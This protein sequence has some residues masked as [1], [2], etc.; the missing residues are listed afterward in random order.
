MSPGNTSKER[1]ITKRRHPKGSPDNRRR[2]KGVPKL[3]MSRKEEKL[4]ADPNR[5]TAEL[6]QDAGPSTII[7]S[8][9]NQTEREYQQSLLA[10]RKIIEATERGDLI[11]VERWEAIKNV[12][13]RAHA[14]M[15]PV[16]VATEEKLFK[17]QRTRGELI[18]V[19]AGKAL[20]TQLISPLIIYIRKMPDLARS[21][22]E[23]TLLQ[24]IAHGELQL[25]TEL[26]QSIAEEE[27]AE[28]QKRLKL[29]E[30]GD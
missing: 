28:L 24:T 15:T 22:S 14:K 2:I 26:A 19:D 25:I 29:R 23:K 8:L 1:V 7:Q 11:E 21:E 6:E 30:K 27:E 16:L 20:M 5:E 12:S 3:R 4:A 13:R 18:T 17:L 9:R 10:E